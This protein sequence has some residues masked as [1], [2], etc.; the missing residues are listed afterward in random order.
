MRV[1][2]N[3]YQCL[4]RAYITTSTSDMYL[5]KLLIGKNIFNPQRSPR[6]V[7]PSVGGGAIWIFEYVHIIEFKELNLSMCTY[8][9]I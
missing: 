7:G 1:I 9:Y 5:F 4:Y 6:P 3:L 2:R 8:P